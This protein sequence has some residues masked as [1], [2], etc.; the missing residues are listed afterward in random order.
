LP[1]EVSDFGKVGMSYGDLVRQ[2]PNN[3]KKLDRKL[4][5][6][7]LE[8]GYLED[9]SVKRESVGVASPG[10]GKKNRIFAPTPVPP[11]EALPPEIFK[12]PRHRRK[13]LLV[14]RPAVSTGIASRLAIQIIPH[15]N[16]EIFLSTLAIR[17]NPGFFG[18]P[19]TGQTAPKK[20]SNQPYPQRKPDP[21]VDFFVYDRSGKC[22]GVLSPFSLNMVYYTKKSDIR[23]T[24]PPSFARSIPAGSILV[25]T[26]TDKA[27][28]GRDYVL[29]AYSPGSTDH[30][31]YLAACNQ[32][33]P[34]GGVG[35]GRQMGWL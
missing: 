34:S 18:Y 16:G 21:N 6:A 35:A 19:F 5:E 11:A 20:R 25:I 24:V 14:A 27:T 9:E 7:L 17:Q 1:N 28:T 30:A 22:K 31:R 13:G 3:C 2:F 32:T 15:H 23:I 10:S 26:L 8:D 4:L 33:L 29:E 12:K